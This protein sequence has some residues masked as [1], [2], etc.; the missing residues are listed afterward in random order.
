MSKPRNPRWNNAKD[1]FS[2]VVGEDTVS[3]PCEGALAITFNVLVE[4]EMADKT[5]NKSPRIS[6]IIPVYNAGA[7]L[8]RCLLAVRGQ[9]LRDIEIICVDD[10]SSDDSAAVIREHAALDSRVRL[11]LS[12]SNLGAAAAR[13]RG[14]VVARGEYLGFVDSD[15]HPALDF[16]EKLY[17]KA[18]ETRADV[19]K[20]NYR[21]WGIDGRSLPV[22]YRMNEAIREYKT[23]FS[24]AFC[25]A[26]YRRQFFIEHCVTF[27]E[28]LIDI[29]D[30]IFT[31]NIALLCNA[32]EIV[33]DAEINIRIHNKSATFGAPTVERILAK[34]NGLSQI[35]DILDAQE[36]LDS[37]SYA[38]VCAFWFNSVVM[39]SLQNHTI[40]AFRVIVSALH[41]LSQKIRQHEFCAIEFAKFGLTDLFSA[42][43]TRRMSK[44]ASHIA[45]FYD[46]RMLASRDLRFGLQKARHSQAEG[47]CV[48]IPLYNPHPTAAERASLR[49]CLKVLGANHPIVFFCPKNLDT[50]FYEK[51]ARE[52]GVRWA[53]EKFENDYFKSPVTYSK[54]LLNQDFYIRFIRWE[55]LLI[56]QLDCW[57]FRDELAL[58]CAKGY[59][60]IGAPWFDGY[61]EAAPD[62]EILS[63]S[64]NGGFSLRKVC[65]MIGTLNILETELISGNENP[66][67]ED[68]EFSFIGQN[69]D[70]VIVNLFPRLNTGFKIAPVE[71]SKRFSF[72]MFPERLYAQI[73]RLPFGCHGYEKYNPE[74]WAPHLSTSGN[75]SF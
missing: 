53:N 62:S 43:Y 8:R 22:D 40:E 18:E 7:W 65:S 74:F 58:W 47:G 4:R 20:G 23:N 17:A 50:S 33:E 71:D 29:E 37:R 11:V 25:S 14:L 21:Y 66:L 15:D 68:T 49:Q 36:A 1:H 10:G 28:N 39:N 5:E 64:G 41:D 27:P 6:I 54:L 75:A 31:L 34:F 46:S 19:V 73:G 16:Y 48:A 52:Y 24:F 69:E 44:I 3:P 59:D 26:I 60:Y 30:P 2:C 55:Y 35:L 9:T 51:S 67:D 42:L 61:S 57:V 70:F 12:S 38:F 63:P 56:Y 45:T 32:I 72:E 13:N